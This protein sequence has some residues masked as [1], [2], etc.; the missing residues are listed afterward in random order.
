MIMTNQSN[1]HDD[2]S[3]MMM[4]VVEMVSIRQMN[5]DGH[6]DDSENDSGSYW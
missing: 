3:L 6:Q 5:N 2:E 1:D 4:V